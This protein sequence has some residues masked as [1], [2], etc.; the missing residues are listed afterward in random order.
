MDQRTAVAR[1]SVITETGRYLDLLHTVAAGLGANERPTAAGFQAATAPLAAARLTGATAVAFVVPARTDEI[2]AT[3]ALWRSRGA[4]DLVLWPQPR[5]GRHAFIV[6]AR[7]LNDNPVIPPGTDLVASPET[8][9]ALDESRRTGTPAVSDAY[10]LL[11]DRALPQ[12]RQQ[13][14]FAFVAPVFAPGPAGQD[15]FQG[16]VVMGLRGQDFLGGVLGDASQGLLDGV[17][18]ATD[19]SGRA[20]TVAGYTTRGAHDLRR[21]ATFP[22]ADRHW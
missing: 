17:L 3:Q 15:P 6:L 16:W 21:E 7:T 10:V 22:V 11:R 2:A 12:D 9:S 20:V 13:L 18:R 5:A 14:S 19:D 8:V 1:T 4:A